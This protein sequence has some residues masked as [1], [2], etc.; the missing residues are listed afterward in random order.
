MTI[1]SGHRLCLGA[2]ALLTL[3]GCGGSET[4]TDATGNGRGALELQRDGAGCDQEAEAAYQNQLASVQ[5]ASTSLTL[6]NVGTALVV[7]QNAFDQCM[8]GLGWE[9]TQ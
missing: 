3:A 6:S 2:I 4:F 5:Y 1:K 8:R 9:R 7:K